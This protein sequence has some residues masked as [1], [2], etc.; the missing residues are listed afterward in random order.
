MQT[1]SVFF[2]NDT[3]AFP[4]YKFYSPHTVSFRMKAS[5]SDMTE[6][7]FSQRQ[8]TI[9]TYFPEELKMTCCSA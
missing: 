7:A 6:A 3:S 9:G 8:K 5:Q 1:I 2:L 4:Q